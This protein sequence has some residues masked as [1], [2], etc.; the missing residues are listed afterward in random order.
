MNSK[1]QVRRA[2][3]IA[4]LVSTSAAVAADADSTP[5]STGQQPV[6]FPLAATKQHSSGPVGA[7][8][9]VPSP[10]VTEM[11]AVLQAD[12]SYQVICNN[13]PNPLARGAYPPVKPPLLPLKD[14]R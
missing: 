2:L 10:V 13:I 7:T 6:A 9:H 3:A 4:L 5:G 1:I 11:R 14:A 8:R 12:G